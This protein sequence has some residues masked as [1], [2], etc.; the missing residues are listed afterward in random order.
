[1]SAKGIGS[2]ALTDPGA[3]LEIFSVDAQC[4]TGAIVGLTDVF[5]DAPDHNGSFFALPCRR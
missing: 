1:M 3:T 4:L 2:V 5:A